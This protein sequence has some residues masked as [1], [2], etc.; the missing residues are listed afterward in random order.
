MERDEELD[1]VVGVLGGGVL[2]DV[3]LGDESGFDLVVRL[4][5]AF[6]YLD[7]RVVLISTRGE[8]DY[9]ELSPD[10]QQIGI[11]LVTLI[12]QWLEKEGPR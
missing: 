7:S 3:G 9:G 6:P 10:E 4:V 11:D 2:V 1:V 12:I 8:D 5:D